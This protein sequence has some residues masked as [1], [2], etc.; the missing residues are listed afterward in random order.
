MTSCETESGRTWRT[1]AWRGACAESS[2]ARERLR[3]AHGQS[4]P[5]RARV[6]PTD[7]AAF[8]GRLRWHAVRKVAIPVGTGFERESPR[9]LVLRHAYESETRRYTP[10]CPERTLLYR[11]VAENLETLLQTAREQ[12][13]SGLGLPKYVEK[14]FRDFLR[15]GVL[16]HGITRLVCEACGRKIFLAFSCKRRGTCSSC[17]GTSHVQ[18]CGSCG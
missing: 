10:R 18:H 12:N 9:P 5:A 15:C 1:A 17:G 3:V 14:E 11:T 2:G 8:L 7:S 4:W 16:C 6:R 13:E